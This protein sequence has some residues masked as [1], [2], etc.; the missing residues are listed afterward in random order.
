MLS[1]AAATAF[2]VD[3]VKREGKLFQLGKIKLFKILY[4]ADWEKFRRTDETMFDIAWYRIQMGPALRPD[5][6]QGV[7]SSIAEK[8][9]ITSRWEQPGRY[10]QFVF[11][12]SGPLKIR[13]SR[14]DAKYLK[15]AV[16]AVID[17]TA[18]AAAQL[19]YQT[20]PMQWMV[21]QEL[22]AGAGVQFRD[23]RI[24]DEERIRFTKL[25]KRYQRGFINV[26][27]IARQMGKHWTAHNV[28]LFLD[29]MGA[30]RP[31]SKLPLPSGKRGKVLKSLRQF[32]AQG[33][34]QNSSKWVEDC[35][36]ASQRI[37]GIY[38]PL[39]AFVEDA[40]SV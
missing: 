23:F 3:C 14:V 9:G 21:A 34:V 10:Q 20:E 27:E 16:K 24:K 31:L 1:L 25:A 33:D 32:A 17:A 6:W 35:V 12:I 19:T 2:V 13:V 29:Q 37:E 8:Y 5:V 11:S 7:V 22:A 36:V 28:V 18:G 4:L 40:A 15:Q 38:V 26:G 39:D 30:S